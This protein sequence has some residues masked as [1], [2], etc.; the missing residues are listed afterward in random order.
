MI[1]TWAVLSIPLWI[2]CGL[3]AYLMYNRT[4][5]RHGISMEEI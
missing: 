2:F 4:E 3:I 1:P 5:L